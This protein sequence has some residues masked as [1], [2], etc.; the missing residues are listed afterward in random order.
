MIHSSLFK[1]VTITNPVMNIAHRGARA[2]APEN[3]L[4]AFAK[5]KDFG[6]QMFELDVRLSK[7]GV[8][9]VHHDEN[10]LRCTDV[11]LKFPE[12]SGDNLI[13]FTYDELLMLDAGSWYSEQLTLPP[14][15]RQRFLQTLTPEELARFVSPDDRKIYASGAIKISTLQQALELADR[16]ELLVNIEL[17]MPPDHYP[18]FSRSVAQ[19][20]QEMG[21]EQR[22]LISSFA[23]AQVLQIREFTGTIPTAALIDTRIENL[24][25]YLQSLGVDAYHPNCYTLD[26]LTG[27]HLLNVENLQ[28][29]RDLG[30]G[31][32]VWTCNDRLAMRQLLAEGVTGLISD[33]PNRVQAVLKQ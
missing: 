15:Q 24:A 1:P 12:R 4:A 9:V 13:D 30:Y 28:T 32:N 20:V 27:T 31:V 14:A 33:F 11:A 16:M 21:L 7:D 25:T 8:L 2:F 3:T 5:A 23:H 19:L 17:K 6:C 10:L 22:V 18:D 26:P 29:I